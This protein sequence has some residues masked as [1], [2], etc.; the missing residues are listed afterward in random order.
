MANVTQTIPNFLGGVSAQPDVDMQPGFLKECI[1]GTPDITFGLQKRQGSTYQMSLPKPVGDAYFT[2][3]ELKDCAWFHVYYARIDTYYLLCVKPGEALYAWNLKTMQSCTV[4]NEKYDGDDN[5]DAL[6]YIKINDT[7]EPLTWQDYK[8]TNINGTVVITN[9][10]CRVKSV[11]DDSSKTLTGTVSSIADLPVDGV[12][13][14]DIYHVLNTG[15]REDDYY[16]IWDGEA[17]EETVRPL[18]GEGIDPKTFPHLI[19][20]GGPTIV[21][22]KSIGINASYIAPQKPGLEPRKVGDSLTNPHPSFVNKFINNCFSYLNR[23]GVITQSTVVLSRP[24][25][26]ESGVFFVF[27]NLD[28]YAESTL[29]QSAADP[30]DLS[31]VTI[32]DI[33]LTCVQ[34]AYQGLVVFSDNEQFMLYSDQGFISPQTAIFKSIS[35]YEMNPHVDA[36]EL[37]DEY[38]F[39]SKGKRSTKLFRMVTRG[40]EQGPILTEASKIVGD[41][42][43]IT[44]TALA[45]N[46]QN[47][48]IYLS[49]N[50]TGDIF[51]YRTFSEDGERLVTNW[52]KWHFNG[53]IQHIFVRDD[54]MHFV[55]LNQN[56]VVYFTSELGGSPVDSFLTTNVLGQD[57]GPF[58]DLWV[59]END[60]DVEFENEY[61]NSDGITVLENP[62]ITPPEGY[63]MPP[64]NLTDVEYTPCV[65]SS[66]QKLGRVIENPTTILGNIYPVEIKDGKWHVTGTFLDT[67]P[68]E[69]FNIGYRYTYQLQFPTLYFRNEVGSD[70]SS[71]LNVSRLKFYFREAGG[72][73]FETQYLGRDREGEY[74]PVSLANYYKANTN[75]TGKL[76]EFLVPI[77]QRN[78]HFNFRITSDSP[79]PVTLNKMMWEGFYNPRYYRRT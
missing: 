70:Y 6:D 11:S 32:R 73:D 58:L 20:P 41:Y 78:D 49:G 52:S 31:A 45:S 3:D 56:K 35:T 62:I 65:I 34:P 44:L 48:F 22:I 57:T 55:S 19:T 25:K 72:I 36:V 63:P 60:L 23:F 7:N 15:V 42:L 74:K 2:A 24:L 13:T 28:F 46:S 51:I 30:V 76:V 37:G 47:K 39:V 16:V 26:P 66:S 50:D 14:G 59:G 9:T 68:I 18:E 29:V 33:N 12:T 40:L 54:V 77:H 43:P 4:D 61:I 17:W 8:F 1:N 64:N 10:K 21:Q 5:G 67:P 38:Y 69:Y 79:Y 27:Q 53:L 71:Y 75:P